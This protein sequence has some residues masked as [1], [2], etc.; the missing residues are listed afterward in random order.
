MSCYKIGWAEY[1]LV[2][3]AFII[4]WHQT[5]DSL[6]YSIQFEKKFIEQNVLLINV[7]KGIYAENF[8]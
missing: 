3:Y 6:K 8:S 7:F 2:N 5:E 1:F 4:A